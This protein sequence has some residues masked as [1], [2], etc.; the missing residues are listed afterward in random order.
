MFKSLGN[1]FIIPISDVIDTF[2]INSKNIIKNENEMYIYRYR[3]EYISMFNINYWMG[4]GDFCSRVGVCIQSEYGCKYIF[5]V[6]E[7]I[8]KN[9]FVIKSIEKNYK[10]INGFSASTILGDG[11]L[12]LIVDVNF[13]AEKIGHTTK[14]R[15]SDE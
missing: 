8:D 9:R 6:D 15:G 13:F 4:G 12:A 14:N 1:K 10:N 5:S 2:E 7:I 11:S 3:N